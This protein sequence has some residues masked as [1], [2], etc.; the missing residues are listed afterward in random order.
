MALHTP[1]HHAGF[2][3]D[4]LFRNFLIA[5]GLAI[6]LIVAVGLVMTT[7]V[8]VGPAVAPIEDVQS[9][10]QYR[11]AERAD[12]AAGVPTQASS[13][14]QFRAAERADLAAG[15]STAASSLLEFR[16]SEREGR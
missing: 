4:H 2:A 3:G 12:W 16:A 13:V 6:A 11:A 7:R 15:V 5:V 10:V 9:L 1:V 8:S 14:V